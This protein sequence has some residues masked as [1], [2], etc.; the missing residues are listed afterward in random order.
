[1]ELALSLHAVALVVHVG[2]LHVQCMQ[3]SLVV[4]ALNLCNDIKIKKGHFQVRP[5]QHLA[6]TVNLTPQSLFKNAHGH[7]DFLIDQYEIDT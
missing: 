4:I 2:F 5:S 6:Y 7:V 3:L 1:M